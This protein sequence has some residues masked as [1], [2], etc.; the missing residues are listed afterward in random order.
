MGGGWWV[1]GGGGVGGAWRDDVQESW[2]RSCATNERV[3]ERAGF[4]FSSF[5]LSLALLNYR[6]M[7]VTSHDDW[8]L[9]K[10]RKKVHT[11]LCSADGICCGFGFMS[12]LASQQYLF[13]HAIPAVLQGLLPSPVCGCH[14]QP[15]L[16]N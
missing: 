12:A 15:R 5:L 16:Q 13:R 8:I 10:E 1:V 6:G 4:Y 2:L 3:T 9:K 7:Q 14:D 11:P